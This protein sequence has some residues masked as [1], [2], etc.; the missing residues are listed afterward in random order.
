[1]ETMDLSNGW[2]VLQDVHD[3]GEESGIFKEDPG[4]SPAGPSI[5]EWEPLP[6]LGHLQT[7]LSSQPYFGRELRYF[8]D[9]PWWYKLEF[10]TP[11][12]FEIH[13]EGS[14][15]CVLR[16]DAVD[17]FAKVWLNGDLLG[18]HE[19]YF[20]PFEFEIGERLRPRA[21]PMDWPNG[22]PTNR[23]VVKVWSPWDSE[24]LEG[25]TER[26]T[27]AV[28][29]NL[30][31]GTYE[32]GDTFIQRDVNPVGLSGGVRLFIHAGLHF[33]GRP[34]I[35]SET[36]GELGAHISVESTLIYQG[37]PK[38]A[39]LRCQLIDR[40][41][42][43]VQAAEAT[44][45]VLEDT[46]NP[47]T[48]I[49]KLDK[50]KLWNTWDRGGANLYRILLSVSR[51]GMVLDVREEAI[52]IRTVELRRTDAETT[53]LLNGERLFLRGTSYFPDVYV[54]NMSEARYRRDLA[55]IKRSGF[56]AI[57][58]HVHVE[59][60]EFYTLCDELGL[61]VIQ[62]SDLN[63]THPQDGAFVSRAV[64]VFR[65]MICELRNHP[66]IIAWV[67]INEPRGGEKGGLLSRSL[68][69]ALLAEAK[70]LDPNRP[71]IKGSGAE[72][73][74]D[75]GDS[76]NY[77][78]S[79]RGY[80]THYTEIYGSR[81]KL[82]TEF[83]FDAPPA[84]ESLLKV[85]EIQ[86][87]LKGMTQ[88]VSKLQIYQYRLLKYY[89]EHYRIQ[90]FDPCSGYFQFMFIDLCPQ[91]FYGIYDYWGIPKEGVRA[92]EESGQPLGIFLEHKDRPV[93][94]WAVNDLLESFPNCQAEWLVTDEK[95]TVCCRGEARADL[96]ANG[97]VRLATADFPVGDGKAYTVSLVLRDARGASLA[98]NVY[99]DPFRHPRH[100][101]GHPHRM[102]HELGMRLYDA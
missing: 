64:A 39:L 22:D 89:I 97:R 31:K 84:D 7:L 38:R 95:A 74:S 19:G 67:C 62:D 2:W 40:E 76:H 101:E 81:E 66:S 78:G 99:Q 37:G 23:L 13:K 36:E 6:R 52:G 61:V 29:R 98:T 15:G 79:L 18:E 32:H 56:N 21:G 72:S 90:K 8:N 59:R 17:Y 11:E 55:A 10:A 33:S 102:S 100:P 12:G 91:S 46:E 47:V 92:H 42:G 30:V 85:P 96:P 20:A 86:N 3:V 80:G 4:L 57:R 5:S 48:I 68:G 1:M 51:D 60:P 44:E 87:R 93:A 83:G 26:R 45:L 65:D 27:G 41:T 25:M 16:F 75:S 88:T 24:I 71:C 77:T 54:S 50:P 94:V 35:V 63:W 58:V 73:D 34:V 69:P 14:A 70:R 82:N 43:L 53:F 9:H 49:L 28:I